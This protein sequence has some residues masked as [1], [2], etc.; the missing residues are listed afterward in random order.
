MTTLTLQLNDSILDYVKAH[1]LDLNTFINDSA[2]DK[3]E[4]ELLDYISP[5]QEKELLMRMADKSPRI[6][7][8]EFLGNNWRH[9]FDEE[10][11]WE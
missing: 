11:G 9:G 7:V 8:D 5:E 1:K 2:M 4:E 10:D 6:S 3:I